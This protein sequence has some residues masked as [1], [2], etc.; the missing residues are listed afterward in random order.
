MEPSVI[1]SII[2]L[3]LGILAGIARLIWQT[4]KTNTEVKQ[5]NAKLTKLA[6]DVGAHWDTLDDHGNRITRV[7]TTLELKLKG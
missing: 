7:E 3:G 6:K 1:I 5:L 4:S 2:S